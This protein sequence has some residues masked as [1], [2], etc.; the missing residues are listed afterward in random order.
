MS[1]CK[2]FQSLPEIRNYR[3]KSIMLVFL[4][5]GSL[6]LHLS[7]FLAVSAQKAVSK[8]TGPPAFFLQDPND[9][10]CLAGDKY[11]RCAID[12]LWYVTGKP[13]S[14][15]INH[16]LVDE[17]DLNSC[18]DRAQC[19]LDESDVQLGSCSHCGARKWNILGEAETGYVLTEDGNKNCLKRVGDKATM[20]KCDKGYSG[21]SL[22]CKY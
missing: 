21:I 5:V 9:G 20:I 3:A 8:S 14:Y 19:H 1:C 22:Q 15:Q 16:R 6:L 2:G 13:G 18:L 17:D 11:R 10:L 4:S 12:T 7:N